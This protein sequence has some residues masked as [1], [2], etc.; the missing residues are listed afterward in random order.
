MR[1]ATAGDWPAITDML[2]GAFADDFPE[3]DRDHDLLVFEPERDLV[4]VEGDLIV[5]NAAAY[6]RDLTV[7]GEAAVPAGHVTLVGV[8]PTYRRRRILTRLMDQQLRDIRAA[9]EPLAVLW[10]SEGRIYQ[11][12]GY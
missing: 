5:G 12:Y 4:M 10:A 1:T 6:T 9:G 2:A 8:R 11:R 3:D 7:P